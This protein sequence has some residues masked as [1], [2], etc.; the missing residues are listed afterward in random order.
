[1]HVNVCVMCVRA[2]A[3]RR[4]E[5]DTHIVDIAT[6]CWQNS[7]TVKKKVEEY[8]DLGHGNY[9]TWYIGINNF[10]DHS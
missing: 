5:F 2:R 3:C 10:I 8:M 1:V 4:K 7:Q 6:V 9:A